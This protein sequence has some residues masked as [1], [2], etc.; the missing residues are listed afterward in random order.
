MWQSDAL[1]KSSL[2]L[3]TT[4]QVGIITSIDR[5]ANWNSERLNDLFKVT[6]VGSSTARM[7]TE[8]CLTPRR[9]SSSSHKLFWE[10]KFLGHRNFVRRQLSFP[11]I[12]QEKTKPRY[13]NTL[14]PRWLSQSLPWWLRCKE[15]ACNVEAQGLIPGSGRSPKK[16]MATHST[17]LA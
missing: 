5:W 15:S 6:W 13:K 12:V 3:W 10:F 14:C 7:Q 1:S 17:I 4:S 9:V 8:V 2:I 16:E 11:S